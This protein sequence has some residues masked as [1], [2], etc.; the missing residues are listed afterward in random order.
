MEWRE[1][2]RRFTP[3]APGF[4]LELAFVFTGEKRK[5]PAQFRGTTT[6]ATTL[7]RGKRRGAASWRPPTRFI[8]WG[9]LG[10]LGIAV[11]DFAELDRQTASLNINEAFCEWTLLR[12]EN[13]R[14]VCGPR[15]EKLW[16]FGRP[17]PGQAGFQAPPPLGRSRRGITGQNPVDFPAGIPE[18]ALRLS[19]VFGEN[20]AELVRERGEGRRHLRIQPRGHPRALRDFQ[21]APA[22]MEK[23]L[24]YEKRGRWRPLGAALSYAR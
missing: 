20:L 12:D 22:G 4:P 2:F 16:G 24:R 1:W 6:S 23:R 7:R 13:C 8:S 15:P 17:H 5:S 14:A 3:V 10:K 19:G 11:F 9:R 18:G 21:F